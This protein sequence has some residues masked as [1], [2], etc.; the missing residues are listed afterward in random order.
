MRR[1]EIIAKLRKAEPVIRA[2]GVAALYVFGSHARDE[3][4]ADSDIDVF[5]DPA[6]DE[7]FGFLE[8]MGV[9]EEIRKV[10]GQGVDIGYSTRDGL[11]PYV[12]SEVE[13]EAICFF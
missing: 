1:D 2:H 7:E 10:F 6:S 11:S 5:V 13:R 4:R 8:F 12:R 9:Y 3:G